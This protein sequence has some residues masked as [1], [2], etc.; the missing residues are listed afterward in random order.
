MDRL[1]RRVHIIGIGGAAMSAIAQ[2]LLARGAQ[3]SGSDSHESIRLA[4]LR[5][6][7]AVVHVGHDAAHLGNPELVIA[8]SAIRDSNPEIVAARAAGLRVR[9]R[10]DWL[11]ELTRDSTLLAIAGTHGKTTT[12]ALLAVVLRD[13]ELDPIAVIGSEVPQL[14]G[15]ALTGRGPLFVLEA[16]EY[17]GAFSGLNPHV[18][19]ITNVEYEHPDYF[20]DER[21]VHESFASF[22]SRVAPTGAL[23]ACGDDPGV[24]SVLDMIQHRRMVI[25]TYGVQSE[26]NWV[27]Q[28]LRPIASGGTQFEIRHNRHVLGSATLRLP[29][30][31]NVLNALAVVATS[32]VL[33]LPISRVLSSVSQFTGAARRFQTVG[34]VRGIE[35]VDDYAHHP[36]E[37]RATLEAARQ[38][39][40]D[41]PVWVVFQP[42]TFSR[43]SALIEEFATAFDGADRVY[44]TDIY[45]ARE[46][47]T[48]GVHASDLVAKMRMPPTIYAPADQ[49][50]D[51]VVRDLPAHA[52]VLTF[53]AGDV[54]Q[55]GPRLLG[56]LGGSGPKPG[57]P[58][59]GVPDATR[60]HY[61]PIP[62]GR[63]G[64]S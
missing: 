11:P 32:S 61:F 56:A 19:V 30:R 29:G 31:H 34:A 58:G 54:T 2:I 7:G 21:A 50:L 9:R 24:R 22:A 3:V 26:W 23:I 51:T 46:Q 53:G 42:H 5:R 6:L 8:S 15:N 60:G 27:A 28:D 25:H 17:D 62:V 12:S 55:F 33:G 52:L 45:A 39:A 40:G 1:Y 36:T 57:Q 59:A 47:N 64:R 37:I 38:R 14:G 10:N 13:L 4:T 16:D 41:R 43:F 18:A 20:K 63:R 48:Y 44:V 49:L 35:V